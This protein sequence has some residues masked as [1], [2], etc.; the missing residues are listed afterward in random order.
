MA[1][2]LFIKR[3]DL[4]R[5][6]ILDGNVDTDDF[7]HYVKVAQE[8]H[9]KN[10]VGSKLYD[11]ISADIIGGSLSGAYLT[12]VNDY[13]QDMLINFA[14]VE[15]LP[16]AGYKIKNGGIFKRSAENSE[17]P[18][19]REIDYLVTK[20]QDRAEYYTRRMI[21]YVTYNIGSYPEYNTNNN[22]DVYPDKDSLFHG[23]VL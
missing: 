7:I 4:V 5:S 11:K 1:T 22:E 17:I 19:K 6:T 12:L 8:I 13:L 20:Y 10:Y 21:D 14:M 16:F 2:A 3:A 9:V 18:S 23:W 15:Y